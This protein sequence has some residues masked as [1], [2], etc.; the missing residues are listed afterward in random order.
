MFHGMLLPCL[1]LGGFF[2]AGEERGEGKWKEEK[3]KG[4]EEKGNEEKEGGYESKITFF[5]VSSFRESARP[6]DFLY[7]PGMH[8]SVT[9]FVRGF[10]PQT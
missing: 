8:S 5:F 9:S 10:R 1:R 6:R 3:G 4:K 7:N 2:E